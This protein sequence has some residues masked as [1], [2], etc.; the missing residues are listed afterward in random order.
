[1]EL[2]IKEIDQLKGHNMKIAKELS[3]LREQKKTAQR[4]GVS[5]DKKNINS[6]K[7][8]FQITHMVSLKV[9]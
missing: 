2:L 8:D 5:N 7:K 9:H 1:M 4:D 6:Q 3:Q